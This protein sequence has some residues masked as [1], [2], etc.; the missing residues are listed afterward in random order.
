MVLVHYGS[1]ESFGVAGVGNKKTLP[2][3]ALRIVIKYFLEFS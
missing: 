3:K 1:A 2:W